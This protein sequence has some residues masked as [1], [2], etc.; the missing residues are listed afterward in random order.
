[1]EMEAHD[2][3]KFDDAAKNEGLFKVKN[4]PIFI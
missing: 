2:F 3:Q 1:M 4:A